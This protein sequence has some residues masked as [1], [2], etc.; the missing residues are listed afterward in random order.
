MGPFWYPNHST[1]EQMFIIWLQ[2]MFSFQIPTVFEYV[3]C[4]LFGVL[5]YSKCCLFRPAF[6]CCAHLKAGWNTFWLFSTY[7]F[8]FEHFSVIFWLKS[9]KKH[10]LISAKKSLKNIWNEQKRLKMSKKVSGPDFGCV[11]H[12][13]AGQNTQHQR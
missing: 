13:K 6:G 4:T 12:P 5:H 9:R 8:N 1:K 3:K 2:N 7:L 10:F 11:W